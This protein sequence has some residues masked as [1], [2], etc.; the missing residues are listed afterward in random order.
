MCVGVFADAPTSK[1]TQGSAGKQAVHR[2]RGN[3]VRKQDSVK[4]RIMLS[5]CM[6]DYSGVMDVISARK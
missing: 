4:T 5:C 2:M 3:L 1:C 6:L